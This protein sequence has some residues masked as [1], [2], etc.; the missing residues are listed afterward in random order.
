M[1]IPLQGRYAMVVEV[2]LSAVD[3][4]QEWQA[5][6][7]RRVLQ[8]DGLRDERVADGWRLREQG[9][10]PRARMVGVWIHGCSHGCPGCWN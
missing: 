7:Q 8:I 1:D 3:A 9:R 2:L 10:D 6:F 4:F 5:F